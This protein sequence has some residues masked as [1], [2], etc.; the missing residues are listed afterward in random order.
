MVIRGPHSTVNAMFLAPPI[1]THSALAQ[2][3][4]PALSF[5]SF[6]GGNY[7]QYG[8]NPGGGA[9]GSGQLYGSASAGGDCTNCRYGCGRV[10]E[11]F[12]PATT[13]ATWSLKLLYTFQ[14]GS[15]GAGP[16]GLVMSHDGTIY[17]VTIGGER[18]RPR[19]SCTLLPAAPTASHQVLL[20]SWAT[21]EFCM[22]QPLWWCNH[23]IVHLGRRLC[24]MRHVFSLTPP[25]APGGTWTF[26]VL[27]TLRRHYAGRP[28]D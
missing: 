19:R 1:F 25:T 3:L 22:A 6:A 18:R 4:Q 21:T 5:F 8:L 26:N 9:G 23:R 24:G 27:Y 12:A 20:C 14:G 2:T 15:D 10:Y 7:G 13:T 11:A 17:G 28:C 16:T